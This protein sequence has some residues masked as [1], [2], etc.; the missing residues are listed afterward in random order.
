MPFKFKT[1]FKSPFTAVVSRKIYVIYAAIRYNRK[2]NFDR[3]FP[4]KYICSWKISQYINQFV[5]VSKEADD[6]GGVIRG[7][8]RILVTSKMYLFVTIVNG[9]R[10]I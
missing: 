5:D 3:S 1:T 10:V 2:L 9:W 8:F 4:L 6:A 7:G